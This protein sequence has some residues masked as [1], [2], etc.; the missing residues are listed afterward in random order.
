MPIIVGC[1]SCG[2]K[3]KAPD[4]LGTR[5]IKCVQCQNIFAPGGDDEEPDSVPRPRPARRPPAGEPALPKKKSRLPEPVVEEALEPNEVG[6]DPEAPRPPRRK[7]KRRKK[8][9]GSDG[10]SLTN[11]R[12]VIATSAFF[13]LIAT[14]IAIMVIK[15]DSESLAYHAWT[16]A[17]MLP[18]STVLWV[19]SMFVGNSLGGGINF[20]EVH[21]VV[22]GS[23]L[24]L[25]VASIMYIFPFGGYLSFLVWA[26]GLVGL[27]G[28]DLWEGS[29]L[30]AINWILNFAF[31]RWLIPMIIGSF[32]LHGGAKMGG[33]VIMPGG[34]GGGESWS[35][36]HEVEDR[37]FFK[38]AD[39]ELGTDS[40]GTTIVRIDLT[41]IPV[42]DADLV[43]LR[44]FD[45]LQTLKL[46]GTRVT[47]AGLDYVAQVKTLRMLDLSDTEVTDEGLQKLKALTSLQILIV[48]GTQVT[49]EGANALKAALPQLKTVVR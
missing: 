34:G 39:A 2:S 23:A 28:V 31:Y 33:A 13:L 10:N 40:D 4:N 37:A 7:K 20:G 30:A 41:K 21:K 15:G 43:H 35:G 11:L 32:L 27:F 18:V 17:I 14:G 16:V 3:L 24:L 1:P 38:Q 26:F 49:P 5:K 44:S 45:Q 48:K 25:V 29:F 36:D 47:D 19:I 22:L 12:V 46:A 9:R 42:G 8:K 6:P